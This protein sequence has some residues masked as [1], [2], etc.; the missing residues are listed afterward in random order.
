M[1]YDLIKQNRKISWFFLLS[2]IFIIYLLQKE[3]NQFFTSIICFLLIATIGVSHG[4]LDN[5]KG[6]KLF[7]MYKIKN[8]YLFYFYYILISFFI[9]GL[10]YILPSL[11]IFSFLLIASYHFGKEDTIFNF[12]NEKKINNKIEISFLLKGSIIII[13]PITFHYQETYEIF[14]LLFLNDSFFLKTL[15]YIK[16]FDITN[17]YELTFLKLLFIASILSGLYLHTC[18]NYIGLGDFLGGDNLIP[19]FISIIALNAIFDPLIAFTIYFCF[20]HSI[21]HTVSLIYELDEKN[22]KNGLNR[23]IKKAIPLTLVTAIMFVFAVYY[24]ANYYVLDD[25]ILKVIFIG[26]ASLTFPHILLEYLL[27]KNE[28]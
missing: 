22:F 25:A 10:W 18:K 7:K 12:D 23:F 27:E 4:S 5:L 16:Y 3:I 20:L 21:R 1:N 9:I 15:N 8:F 11:T 24:L 17:A 28:K 26:L 2:V 19:D 14:S 13:A 6:K